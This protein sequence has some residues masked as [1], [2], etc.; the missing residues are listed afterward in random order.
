MTTQTIKRQIDRIKSEI[1]VIKPKPPASIKVLCEPNP[2]IGSDSLLE[3]LREVQEAKNTHDQVFVSCFKLSDERIGKTVDGVRYYE[4]DVSAA[5][6]RL[7]LLPS[8]QANKNALDDVLKTL[9]GRVLGIKPERGIPL[10]K[11]Q[12][13]ISA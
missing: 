3:F 4:S 11:S 7:A 10:E 8:S 12:M 6:G 13:P 5:C 9:S 2:T 1:D